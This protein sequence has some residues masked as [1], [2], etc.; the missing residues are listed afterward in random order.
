MVEELPTCRRW[1][2]AENVP[3][4]PAHLQNLSPDWLDLAFFVYQ[5]PFPV[6][7]YIILMHSSLLSIQRLQN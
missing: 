7:G 3:S 1:H 4:L 6:D 5:N 2:L